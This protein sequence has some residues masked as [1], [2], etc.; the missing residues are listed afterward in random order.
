MAEEHDRPDVEPRHD[1]SERV[2]H[3]GHADV[4]AWLRQ[5]AEPRQIDREHGAVG[6]QLLVQPGEVAVRHADAVHEHDRRLA[7]LR[8]D[9]RQHPEREV[10]DLDAA[11][12]GSHPVRHR[13]LAPR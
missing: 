4:A 8:R 9:R 11:H 13:R 6:C 7:T 1:A 3:L 2:R 12:R 5:S 10:F